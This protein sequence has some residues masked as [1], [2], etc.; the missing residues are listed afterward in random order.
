MIWNKNIK[1]KQYAI[2]LVKLLFVKEFTG[3]R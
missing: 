1:N 3:S 2:Y